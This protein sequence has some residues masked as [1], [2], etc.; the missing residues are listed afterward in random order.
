MF[1]IYFP[2]SEILIQNTTI[3]TE[4]LQF[5][6]SPLTASTVSRS[7]GSGDRSLF[8]DSFLCFLVEEPIVYFRTEVDQN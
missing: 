6:H 7:R 1:K 8:L 5:W 2:E 4:N 3:T